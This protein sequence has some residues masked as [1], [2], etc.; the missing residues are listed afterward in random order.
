MAISSN[1]LSFAKSREH[2]IN[3]KQIM[4]AYLA[5]GQVLIGLISFYSEGL[6]LRYW[7]NGVKIEPFAGLKRT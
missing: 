3:P 7:V 5:V 4:T 2:W 6:C 1:V